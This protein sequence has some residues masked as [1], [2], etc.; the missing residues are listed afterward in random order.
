MLGEYIYRHSGVSYLCMWDKSLRVH[1]V[2]PREKGI[3]NIE[4]KRRESEEEQRDVLQE[5]CHIEND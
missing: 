5:K 2:N 4:R 3:I 1:I